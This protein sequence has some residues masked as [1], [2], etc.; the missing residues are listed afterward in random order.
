[1]GAIFVRGGGS[2]GEPVETV[3]NHQSGSNRTITYTFV[4]DYELAIITVGGYGTI[5]M[6]AGTGWTQDYTDNN[7]SNR[8]IGWHK[9]HV[10]SGETVTVKC[11]DR[12]GIAIIGIN[13]E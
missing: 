2:V 1:M 11:N 8:A 7:S 9:E 6:T 4:D 10:V 12:F 5:N 3:L 13:A